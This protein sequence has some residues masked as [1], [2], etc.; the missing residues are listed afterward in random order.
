MLALQSK[1]EQRYLIIQSITSQHSTI[2]LLINSRTRKKKQRKNEL[3][4]AAYLKQ[5]TKSALRQK[6]TKYL[7]VLDLTR[8]TIHPRL[9]ILLIFLF[10]NWCFGLFLA[11]HSIGVLVYDSKGHQ[12]SLPGP[13]TEHAMWNSTK[14]DLNRSV[15]FAFGKR[16]G[17]LIQRLAFCR[18]GVS[19][20]RSMLFRFN[21]QSW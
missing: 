15:L 20:R 9:F 3:E 10:K 17:F 8:F 11:R 7:R 16:V 4:W 2:E 5:S 1:I 19:I 14:G 6:T 12:K 18:F 21:Q 13:Q